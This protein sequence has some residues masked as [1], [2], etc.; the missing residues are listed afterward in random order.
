MTVTFNL[1]DLGEGLPE[2]EIV[3][4]H[5]AEGQRVEV[6]QP[7]LSVE[8]AKAVVDVPSPY[9]GKIQRLHAK[10][11]DTVQTGK[12]LVDFD[13]PSQSNAAG[14]SSS[15][16]L[17]GQEKAGGHGAQ[18]SNQG[19]AAGQGAKAPSNQGMVVGHMATRS[20]ELVDHAIVG[21]GRRAFRDRDGGR[22]RAAPAVR[23][24]AKR[25]GVELSAC[26]TTGRHGLVSVD[27]VLARANLNKPQQR[28]PAVAGLT[29][30]D[31][32]RG[33][34]KA[35]AQSM[36]LSRDEIAMCTI[37]DDADI[38]VWKSKGDI[39]IRLI[40]AIVAGVKA[41]PALNALFDPSVPARKLMEPVHLAMAVDTTDG[42]I[43]PVLRDVGSQSP[44]Q[45]RAQLDDI[46]QRTR[47]R[48]ITP[49]E[50]RDYTITLSNFGTV[51]GRYAT[52]LVV[53]PTVAILGAGK[54]QR[55]V[56]AGETAPEIHVRLPLSLTFDH[57]CVT[58]GEA[59]R[60]LAAVIADL[61][62]AN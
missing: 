53:P 4:W 40:R 39:T 25:L 10:Q 8:T 6:D 38:D 43:V 55:D 48:T 46:K 20:E 5:V 33:P 17:A 31:K 34:R 9:S 50:M 29:D 58:G 11:G 23:M 21:R 18:P 56:V 24:L 32:L 35:M 49:E 22:V 37:F 60:F 27:D 1:P 47:S 2:A 19:M 26:G 41:E 62:L 14:N 3:T 57:R 51:A 30:A 12:P 15:P 28:S 45:L 59:L 44:A 52:P 54:L 36:S 16:S 42:L 7:L 61:Q 13:L